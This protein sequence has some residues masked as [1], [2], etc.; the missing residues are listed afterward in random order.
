MKTAANLLEQ[1]H[2]GRSVFANGL[3]R[4]GSNKQLVGTLAIAISVCFLIMPTPSAQ[5]YIVANQY[6][7]QWSGIRVFEKTFVLATERQGFENAINAWNSS[8]TPATFAYT[9]SAGAEVTATS[10]NAGAT[11]WDGLAASYLTSRFCNGWRQTLVTDIT[12]NNFYTGQSKYTAAVLQGLAAHELGHALGLDESFS[13]A[14]VLMNPS[15]FGSL[16]R[17]EGYHIS[18]PQGDDNDGVKF[19]ASKCP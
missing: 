2:R 5:A 9:G 16:S 14:G 6:P 10:L 11:G 12:L 3:W 7:A 15:T 18:T 8:P 4:N 1:F 13:G 19:I 17:W